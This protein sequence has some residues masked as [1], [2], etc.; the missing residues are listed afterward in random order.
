MLVARTFESN[1]RFEKKLEDHSEFEEKYV[2]WHIL[3][4]KTQIF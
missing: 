2:W 1:L 4:R 3:V